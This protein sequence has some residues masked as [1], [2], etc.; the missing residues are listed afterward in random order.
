MA[1]IRPLSELRTNMGEITNIVDAQKRPVYLTKHG[2]GRYVITSIE[3]YNRLTG[4]E[5]LYRLLDEGLKAE[6]D[7]RV[8]DFK[9]FMKEFREDIKHGRI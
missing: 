7:G 1:E 6:A 9:E 4:K 8:Q 2:H 5:E 3:E